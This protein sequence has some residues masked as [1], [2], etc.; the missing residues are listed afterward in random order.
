MSE[1]PSAGSA[2]TESAPAAETPAQSTPAAES[3]LFPERI[4]TERLLLEPR[5][6]AYVDAT[7]VYEICSGDGMERLTRW[8][9]WS[10][11]DAPRTSESFLERGRAGWADGE[12]AAYVIRLREGEPGGDPGEIVGFGG[13][14]VDWDRRAGYLGVWLREPFWGRGY[15]GERADALFDLAFERLD[16]GVVGVAHLPENE[17]AARAITEYVDR[18]GGRRDGRFRNRLTDVDSAVHDTI[19]YSV[20]QPE[21]READ[22]TGTAIEFH[23]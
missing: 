19:E 3:E 4:R 2:G 8:L 23:D 12:T 14:D 9:P 11:H 6:P 16:L 1:T 13:L 21:W 18:H 20:S 17:N 5:T 15:S 10:P 7:R 22:G